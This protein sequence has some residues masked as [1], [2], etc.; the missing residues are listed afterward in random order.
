M[1]CSPTDGTWCNYVDTNGHRVGESLTPVGRSERNVFEPRLSFV[2]TA[3]VIALSWLIAAALVR[4]VWSLGRLVRRP[5][6][7]PVAPVAS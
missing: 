2:V 6:R 4:F 5:Q 3:V 7:V 1:S